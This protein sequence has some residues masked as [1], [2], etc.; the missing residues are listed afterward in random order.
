MVACEIGN[1]MCFLD[2]E[3]RLYNKGLLP[4]LTLFLQVELQ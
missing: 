4:S 3:F 2:L 1:N